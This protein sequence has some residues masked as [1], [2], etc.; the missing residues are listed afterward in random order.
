MAEELHNMTDQEHRDQEFRELVF[1]CLLPTE[2]PFRDG[3]RCL[4]RTAGYRT[5]LEHPDDTPLRRAELRLY[6]VRRPGRSGIELLTELELEEQ[7][8]NVEFQRLA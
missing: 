4:V 5:K 7:I 6:S 2:V 3:S 8:E 1:R